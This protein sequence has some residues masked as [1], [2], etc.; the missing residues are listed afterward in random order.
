MVLITKKKDDF[1]AKVERLIDEVVAFTRERD[2][3]KAMVDQ[4]EQYTTG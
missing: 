1:K 3:L 2:N 4:A